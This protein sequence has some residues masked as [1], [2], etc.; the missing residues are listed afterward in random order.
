MVVSAAM[1]A[2]ALILPIAFHAVGLGSQFLPMLLPLLLNGFLV[3]LPWALLTGATV[4]IISSFMTGMPP[5][6]R[7]GFLYDLP[8]A[9][10]SPTAETGYLG[11][12]L[13]LSSKFLGC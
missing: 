10:P 1:A 2:L 5:T 11:K 8:G 4:P 7:F 13:S 9:R 3:P 6:H 12:C